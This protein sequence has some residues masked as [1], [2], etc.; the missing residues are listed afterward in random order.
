MT[1]NLMPVLRYP[2]RS[3]TG[4]YLR[5]GIGLVIGLGALVNASGSVTLI[6]IF[7]S[8]TAL[9]GGFAYRTRQRHLLRVLVTEEA[10]QTSGLGARELSWSELDLFKLAYYGTRRQRHRE[11]GGGFM[12]LTL[13]GGGT[14]LSL[15]SSIDSFEYI[16]WRAAKAARA[17][18]VGFDPASAGNLLELGIDAEKDGPAPDIEAVRK[19]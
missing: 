3:L 5:A 9:F 2:A 17:N 6:V 7:G 18:G 19:F 1:E 14:S 16:V 10:I 15:E 4:D 11:T 12:Q 13:K 8:L